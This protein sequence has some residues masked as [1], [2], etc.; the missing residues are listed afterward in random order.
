MIMKA[1]TN[2][3]VAIVGMCGAGKSQVADYLVKRGYAYLRFGQ[4]TLDL[5]KAQ[6][7]EINEANEKK[8]REGLRREHGMG[9][10]AK[11]NLSKINE[12]LNEGKCVVVDGLYSWSE[13]KVLKENY[14]DKLYVLAVYAPPKLRYERLSQRVHNKLNDDAVRFRM[15]TPEQAQARDYA[16]IENIEKGGPIVMADY[17]IINNA[18]F[19]KMYKQIDEFLKLIS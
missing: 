12:M 15:L 6:G 8:I 10:Y 18:D 5:L 19:K 2:K 1:N 17:T 11:L 7:L 9:A 13:Y 16:E 14:K 4:V 3:I